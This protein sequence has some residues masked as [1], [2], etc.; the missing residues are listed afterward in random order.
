MCKTAFFVLIMMIPSWGKAQNQ[1]SNRVV[2]DSVTPAFFQLGEVR[3]TAFRKSVIKDRISQVAMEAHNKVEVSR[4]LNLLAGVNLTASGPRNESMVSVRG[5]DLRAVPVYMDGIPVYVPY[6]GYVDLARFTTF[7]LS[8]ID[9]SRGFSSLLYGPNSLGGAINLIS[10][11]PSEKMEYD[12]SLG[13]INTNGY[14]GNLNIGSNLGKYYFQAGYSYL[15]RDSYRMASGFTTRPYEDGGERDNSY[16]TD[17]MISFKAGWT[18]NERQEYVLGYRFQKGEKGTPV[19]VGDD[20]MNPLYTKPRF[21]QWPDWDKETYYFLSNTRLKGKDYIKSRMY[22]D[23]FKNIL[24]SYDDASYTAQTKAYAFQSLYDDYTYGGSVE[25]GTAVI[26]KNL[27]KFSVHYKSDIHREHNS[28]EPVR[29]FKDNTG[30]FA[31]EN[32]YAVTEKLTFIPGIGYSIR[33][34]DTAEDYNSTTQM[35]SDFEKTGASN[36]WNG[37][38]GVFYNFKENQKASFTLAHKTRFATIKD[39]YS[40]RM[41]TAIPNPGL[42]PEKAVNYDLSYSGVFFKV[43]STQFSVYYSHLTDAILTVNNVEP[44][45]SQMQNTGSAEFMGMEITFKYDFREKLSLGGNYSYIERRN[46]TNPTV[47]FTDIP[48]TKVFFYTQYKPIQ[49]IQWLVSTEFNASR[50]STSYGTRAA[51]FTLVNTAVSARVWRYMSVEAGINNV[52]DKNYMLVE[53]YPEEGR[54]FFVTLRIFKK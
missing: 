6:D 17:Q 46:T 5:F 53:G 21:W 44:G 14:R 3:I 43:L 11:K 48:D 51:D 10:K 45:K 29:N 38:L 37:Q 33:K 54:N 1:E 41:G 52:F 7:D 4:S 8:A 28:N 22:Y 23:T 15:H 13:L 49:P 19:Y 27:L 18:P 50:N 42:K 35:V 34:N 47:L 36:A 2:S 31:V 40:Y 30:S 39:R 20:P 16:R 9:V 12:G 25:F 32:T 26:P 24:N